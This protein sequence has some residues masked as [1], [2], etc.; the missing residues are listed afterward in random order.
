MSVT[1]AHHN[2]VSR[3]V[4]LY[5]E[6]FS[7]ALI[8]FFKNGSQATLPASVIHEMYMQF[9]LHFLDNSKG[10]VVLYPVTCLLHLLLWKHGLTTW[11]CYWWWLQGMG[12]ISLF[13]LYTAED[14]FSGW[15][16][17]MWDGNNFVLERLKSICQWYCQD[18]NL[19]RTDWRTALLVTMT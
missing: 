3:T 12:T 15:V 5:V 8:S 11:A 14:I 9:L 6:P 13:Q 1:L 16:V 17:L 7:R 4:L 19:C 2:S 10:C 18:S